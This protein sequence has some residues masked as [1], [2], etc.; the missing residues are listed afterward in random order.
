MGYSFELESLSR[1]DIY[2]YIKGS[3][4]RRRSIFPV[5]PLAPLLSYCCEGCNRSRFVEQEPWRSSAGKQM[6]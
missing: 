5:S 2:S 1:A 4:R 3:F 6:R